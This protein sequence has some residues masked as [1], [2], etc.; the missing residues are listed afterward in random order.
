MAIEIAPEVAVTPRTRSGAL[1]RETETENEVPLPVVT[2]GVPSRRLVAAMPDHSTAPAA[3]PSLPGRLKVIASPASSA[4]V[5]F[6]L[7]TTARAF[8]A[9]VGSVSASLVHV[10]PRVSVMV[11]AP[12]A[13]LRRATRAITVFPAAK[14]PLGTATVRVVPGQACASAEAFTSWMLEVTV[15]VRVVVLALPAASRVRTVK[16]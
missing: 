15:T 12:A 9:P 1:L 16:E 14:P 13:G 8:G 2:P 10:L 3:A 4:V 11:T 7:N 5:T 6:A